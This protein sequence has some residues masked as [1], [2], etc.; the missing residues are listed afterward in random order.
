MINRLSRVTIFE[1]LQLHAVSSLARDSE[2]HGIDTMDLGGLDIDRVANRERIT[3]W[4]Q[5]RKP[6][7]IIGSPQCRTKEHIQWCCSLY[8][9]QA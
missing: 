3:A 5:K 4:V 8:K 6:A 1:V 7:F 9:L 2:K